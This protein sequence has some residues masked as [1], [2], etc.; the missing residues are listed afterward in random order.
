MKLVTFSHNNVL[1]FIFFFGILKLIKIGGFL[2]YPKT[3]E[4]IEKLIVE[5]AIPGANYGF[6]KNDTLR[7]YSVGL[8]QIVP[9]QEDLTLQHQY[10][11]ASLTKV[12]GTTT[13]ILQLWEKGIIDIYQPLHTYY[14]EFK[15]TSITILELLTHT[16]D[17][18]AYI[19][20]RDALSQTELKAALLLLKP[21]AGKGRVMQYTD[22]GSLL[23]GFYLEAY[24]QQPIQLLITE[25]VL[26]PIGMTHSTFTPEP[27]PLIAPTEQHPK[28]GLIKG[29]VH[30]PKAFTLGEN[31]GSAGLFSTI[32]DCLA[33]C[34]M[35]L[36]GGESPTGKRLLNSQ[37]IATLYHDWTK[38]QQF[39]RSLG[40]DLLPGKTA[41][42]PLLYHTGYT[43]TFMIIDSENQEAFVF[44]SNRVHPVDNREDYLKNRNEL[45][46][47]YL[48]EK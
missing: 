38:E 5:K 18:Q 20:N 1:A 12:I 28:R 45:I 4:F 29:Q 26:Q 2:M 31:C 11:V 25:K 37:T 22:T 8:S 41:E 39:M 7:T 48:N 9:T 40:W 24:Y 32:E 33:F 35:I 44:L 46:D 14:P 30:D 19:E 3:Q 6:I 21:G 36:N 23:L 10:D 13:L 27:N 43:G 17:V 47:L 15:D 42:H 34:Q 16:S